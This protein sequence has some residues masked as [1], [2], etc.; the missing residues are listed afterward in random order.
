M[1]A[2]GC[3]FATTQDVLG[4]YRWHDSAKCQHTPWKVALEIGMVLGERESQNVA[5]WW[6]RYRAQ[7]DDAF[8]HAIVREAENGGDRA[9]SP[10][11]GRLR[12]KLRS[13]LKAVGL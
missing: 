7:L 2:K 6:P 4:V 11:R 9:S 10:R 13:V 12:R 3:E 1:F 5:A 8:K